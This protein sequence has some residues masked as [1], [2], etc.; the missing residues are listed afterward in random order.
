MSGTVTYEVDGDVAV[1]TLRRPEKL[2]ALSPAMITGLEEAW[3]RYASSDQRCAVLTSEGDRAF[4]A[5]IDLGDVSLDMWRCVPNLSVDLDKPV[6]AAITGHCIGGGWVLAQ[7]SDLIVAS[8]TARFSYPEGKVGAFGGLASGV[9][10]RVPSKVAAEFLMLGEPITAA[11]AYDVGMINAVVPP[12]EHVEL[13]MSWAHRLAASAPLVI[14]TAKR[15]IDDHVGRA[16]VEEQVRTMRLL[17]EVSQSE[18]MQEGIAAFREKR[19]P[20]FTGR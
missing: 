14:R 2:N 11:R 5:G 15:L 20:R 8:E 18:D 4:C 12:G 13:A 16:A 7:Y 19:E 1:V 3:A 10:S 6:V 9:V 17:R